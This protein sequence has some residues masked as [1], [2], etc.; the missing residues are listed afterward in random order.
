MDRSIAG[1]H[2]DIRAKSAGLE[3]SKAV[4]ACIARRLC[5]RKSGCCGYTDGSL[6][7]ERKPAAEKIAPAQDK[8]PGQFYRL[9]RLS[10]FDSD[11]AFFTNFNTAFAAKALIRIDRFGF[12]VY[13][14]EYFDRTNVYALFTTDTFVFV[15]DGI[16]SHFIRLL[17]YGIDAKLKFKLFFAKPK[18]PLIPIAKGSQ[19]LFPLFLTS[20][21]RE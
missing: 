6:D 2:G 3:K 5:A 1:Q 12:A 19:A 14:F 8:R 9:D 20:A 13:Q 17:S 21:E 7:I 11:G 18:E 16:K 10:L 15:H 4:D